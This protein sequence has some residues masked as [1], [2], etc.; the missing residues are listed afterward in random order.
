MAK[1]EITLTL[2]SKSIQNA[3]QQLQNYKTEVLDKTDRFARRL[4]EEGVEIAQMKVLEMNA[5]FKGE[6]FDSLRNLREGNASYV[7]QT[8]SDH[9]MFVEFGT[10]YVGSAQQYP[11]P[12]PD[13]V[14]WEYV[15]GDQIL[16]NASKGIYG[17]FYKKEGKTYFTEGMPARPFMHDAATDLMNRVVRV[18]KEVFG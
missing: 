18:A 8:N 14:N 5:V 4:S 6:L 16:A 3:M 12:F 15:S 13:G 17:W 10:G 2:D 1:R 9:A 7:V 11:Y